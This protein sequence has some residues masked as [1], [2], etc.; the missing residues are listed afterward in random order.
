MTIKSDKSKVTLDFECEVGGE[1]YLVKFHYSE[2]L[3]QTISV[4]EKE[5]S[6]YAGYPVELFTEI[7]DF[8]RSQKV[9]GHQDNIVPSMSKGKDSGGGIVVAGREKTEIMDTALPLPDI[10]EVSEAVQDT[11]QQPEILEVADGDPVQSFTSSAKGKKIATSLPDRETA[12][13]TEND[14]DVDSP[15][16]LAERQKA[17]ERA[18]KSPKTIKPRHE[19]E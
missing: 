14:L 12:K 6:S 3:G 15:E 18:S 1:E 4:C 7:V 9:I 13:R 16:I 11:V 17:V 19:E 10:S 2:E 5:E 8:L